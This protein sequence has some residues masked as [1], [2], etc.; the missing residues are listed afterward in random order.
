MLCRHPCG[1]WIREEELELGWMGSTEV[2]LKATNL[3]VQGREET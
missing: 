1:S 3:E 2:K